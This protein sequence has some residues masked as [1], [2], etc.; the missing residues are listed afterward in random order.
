MAEGWIAL[1]RK[2]CDN[3]IWTD[4]PF[5]KGQAWID[6]LLEANHDRREFLLGSEVTICARGQSANSVKTWALRWGWS[7]S[8]VRRF[9]DLLESCLMIER[10]GTTKT[11]II[12]IC[13]YTDYQDMR[14]T[15]GERM[16]NERR[17]NGERAATNNNGNN[18][19]N[20]NKNTPAKTKYAE[21]VL[22]TEE[23]HAKLVHQYGEANVQRMITKLDNY[24]GAKGKTYKSDYR[25]ILSWVA[26]DVMKSPAQAT[27]KRLA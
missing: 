19:N 11:T 14:R 10:K 26:D 1:H 13:R 3:W 12:T 20:G 5:S 25:A 9:H 27:Q 7:E 21:F 22:M 23:E 6:M 24:K 17:T 15:D 8:K 4:K 2:I 18:E 16:A